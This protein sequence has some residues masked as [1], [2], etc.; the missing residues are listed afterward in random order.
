MLWLAPTPPVHSSSDKVIEIIVMSSPSLKMET[1]KRPKET[2]KRSNEGN[3]RDVW[4]G[5]DN[6]ILCSHLENVNSIDTSFLVE[7]YSGCF[8]VTTYMIEVS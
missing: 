4:T 8:A 3:G 7:Q 5:R 2:I 1:R 6:C